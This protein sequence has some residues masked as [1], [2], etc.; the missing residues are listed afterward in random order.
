A[1]PTPRRPASRRAT[2][3]RTRSPSGSRGGPQPRDAPQRAES[4][5][6]S[7]RRSGTELGSPQLTRQGLGDPEVV[8]RG[9][10]HI[11]RRVGHHL[12]RESRALAYLGIVG[13]RR[14]L[15]GRSFGIGRLEHLTW[16][17]L[18]S[19][20]PPQ[21]ISLDGSRYTPFFNDFF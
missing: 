1:R 10:L 7:P 15:P 20:C 11:V 14:R 3:A 17:A 6:R 5:R 2:R 8:G 19:L 13:R 16:E 21:T 4:P 9:D 12:D 18:G